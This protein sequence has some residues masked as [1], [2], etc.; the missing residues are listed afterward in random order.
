MEPLNPQQAIETAIVQVLRDSLKLNSNQCDRTLDGRPGAKGSALFVGVWSDG[1]R[2]SSS[3]VAL[4]EK[5]GACVTVTAQIFEPMDRAYIA[6]D[7]AEIVLNQVR[8]IIH[9]D[10]W[11]NAIRRKSNELAGLG[12]ESNRN[13]GFTESLY[14]MGVD[15][16]QEKSGE[17]FLSLNATKTGIAW[18][19]RFFGMRLIQSV[20]T[21]R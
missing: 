15:S 17:W 13:I 7:R 11:N 16:W 18:T 8:S 14:L 12:T 3:R 19:A 6:K 10:T 21:A 2:T 9:N 1:A 20:S 5:Y 4:D